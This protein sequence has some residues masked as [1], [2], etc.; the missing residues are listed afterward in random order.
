MSHQCP[1]L[2]SSLGKPPSTKEYPVRSFV[3][4]SKVLHLQQLIESRRTA[5]KLHNKN[6]MQVDVQ[7]NK[8]NKDTHS[9]N[10]HNTNSNPPIVSDQ[11]HNHNRNFNIPIPPHFISPNPNIIIRSKLQVHQRLQRINN[12]R[13]SN[14]YNNDDFRLTDN[15]DFYNDQVEEFNMNSHIDSYISFRNKED[16]NTKVTCFKGTKKP[17][18]III[19]SGQLAI[20]GTDNDKIQ[21]IIQNWMFKDQRFAFLIPG[22][23]EIL[24]VSS[25]KAII[26]CTETSYF[27]DNVDVKD[28]NTTIQDK[29]SIGSETASVTVKPRETVFVEFTA[30]LENLDPTIKS[31]KQIQEILPNRIKEYWKN[32]LIFWFCNN[33][34]KNGYKLNDINI[35]D[36]LLEM[37]PDY[38]VDKPLFQILPSD[39]VKMDAVP[40]QIKKYCTTITHIHP[41]NPSFPCYYPQFINSRKFTELINLMIPMIVLK[42]RIRVTH[43][44]YHLKIKII[45]QIQPSY[46]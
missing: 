33:V 30:A 32:K 19:N 40:D 10:L 44:W 45:I 37:V 2:G 28:L 12:E 16:S 26:Q 36:F 39:D 9:D 21:T 3:K 20:H 15:G 29:L 34:L 8:S 25:T 31:P 38:D 1:T 4:A 7:E 42:H 24:R 41:I 18:R 23:Y 17:P 11:S 6:E 22:Q 27:E 43:Q 13:K 46:H 35:A 5:Q 14:G